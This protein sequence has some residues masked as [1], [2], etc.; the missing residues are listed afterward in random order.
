MH[1]ISSPSIIG[2][3]ECRGVTCLQRE[4]VKEAQ[5]QAEISVI[6]TGDFR[7]EVGNLGLY[8]APDGDVFE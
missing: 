4:R 1:G 7:G 3:F 5:L 6:A 2:R 8:A